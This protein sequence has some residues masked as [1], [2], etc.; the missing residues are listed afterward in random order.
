MCGGEENK[1]WC[2]EIF[3]SHPTCIRIFKTEMKKDSAPIRVSTSCCYC[4]R[5]QQLFWKPACSRWLYRILGEE[6]AF[7]V[8]DLSVFILVEN[9]NTSGNEKKKIYCTVIYFLWRKLYMFMFGGNQKK[10]SLFWAEALPKFSIF[11]KTW[12]ISGGSRAQIL[13]TKKLVINFAWWKPKKKIF[14]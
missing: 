4:N 3:F 14:I 10:K 13:S 6:C 8:I 11:Y 12:S 7:R 9:S 5:D 2:I 1:L